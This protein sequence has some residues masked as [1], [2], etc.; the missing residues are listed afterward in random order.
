MNKQQARKIRLKANC[1]VVGLE[2][3]ASALEARRGYLRYEIARTL[4]PRQH[5]ELWERSM[6]GESWDDMIDELIVE[7]KGL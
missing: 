3:T 1:H 7:R 5:S 4:D 6:A 2:D